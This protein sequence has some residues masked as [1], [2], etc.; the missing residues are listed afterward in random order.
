M[1]LAGDG[2]AFF[3]LSFDEAGG[4]AFEFETAA[5]KSLITLAGLALEAED[6]PAADQR[7]QDAG[8][9]SERDEPDEAGFQSLKA[10][11]YGKIFKGKFDVR[12]S[13]EICAVS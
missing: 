12:S 13:E 2:A 7:H 10:L 6:V 4:E 5:G 3:F 9:E 8:E 11:G 1:K